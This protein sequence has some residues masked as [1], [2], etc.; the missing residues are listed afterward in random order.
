MIVRRGRNACFAIVETFDGQERIKYILIGATPAACSRQAGLRIKAAM[1]AGHEASWNS[2]GGNEIRVF[3]STDDYSD[4]DRYI[5]SRLTT[6][7]DR[8]RTVQHRERRRP[9]P[10]WE[11]LMECELCHKRRIGVAR[12]RNDAVG[13]DM[14]V[15]PA[16]RK[17]VALVNDM[18]ARGPRDGAAA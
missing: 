5:R 10:S 6:A 11:G 7:S 8:G 16:D 9:N 17:V 4:G 1:K 14:M 3:R 2:E 18:K 15:C 13:R 12:V